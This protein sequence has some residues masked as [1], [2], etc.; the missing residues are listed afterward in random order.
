MIQVY[1]IQVLSGH[2]LNYKEEGKNFISW[3]WGDCWSVESS[4]KE[5]VSTFITI[6]QWFH[7]ATE[8][9]II[10]RCERSEVCMK[11]TV[12]YLIIKKIN[13]TTTAQTFFL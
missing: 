2:C 4:N 9:M 10:S 12:L 7:R 5:C 13:R 1:N 8:A 11:S 6:L 3:Q